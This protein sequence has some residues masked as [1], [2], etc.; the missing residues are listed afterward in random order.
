M[1]SE[2][3]PS[4]D[5]A[6][7]PILEVVMKRIL[8]VVLVA[9]VA[10]A[11]AVAMVAFLRSDD[12]VAA[13]EPA[14]GHPDAQSRMAKALARPLDRFGLALL[15]R[16]AAT[17][18]TGN[19][20]VSPVSLHAVL[21]MAFNGASDQTAEEMRRVL[22]LD[23]MD[24]AALNQGWADLIWLAQSG[25]KHEVSIADSLWLRDGFPFRPS[26]LDTNREYFAAEMRALPTEPAQAADE[27]NSWVEEH[28]AGRIK[29][30]VTPSSFDAQ[31]ILALFN[32]VHLKV[33][34][35]YFDKKNTQPAPFT[36]ASGERVE[37]PMMS[38]PDL[39]AP[40][41][42]TADYDA[43]ALKT[44]GPVTVW[45]IV[46]KGSETAESLLKDLDAEQLEALYAKAAHAQGSLELPRFT[47]KYTADG[48]KE[49]LAAMGMPRAFSPDEAEFP[50][51]ADVAPERIF[52]QKA[53][54]KTFLDLNEEGVEAAG[55]SGLIVGVTSAP[56]NLF[57]IRAD[58]PFLLVLTEN[59]T[60]APLFMGLIR[61][62][63]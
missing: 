23:S 4:R 60:K 54:Q 39:E 26:F 51:I 30:I 37:V 12:T 47:T 17:S 32:T 31:T 25:E 2:R 45:V 41:A 57:Q 29:D 8:L 34:W 27:I 9:A 10:V 7:E 48:L 20:V 33:K 21:S 63:R 38:A 52:I 43:V 42:Q 40:V 3:S 50:G 58:H 28:T 59:A 15:Q 36:L 16:Q 13:A 11:V 35:E 61:D 53:V 22:G 46:P 6:R 14:K 19:V 56:A 18:P 44:D 1:P 55:A 49:N 62:P 24:L 5:A